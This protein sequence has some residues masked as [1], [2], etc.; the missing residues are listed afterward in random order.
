MERN[1]RLGQ[2][3]F[4]FKCVCCDVAFLRSGPDL[5]NSR[6]SEKKKHRK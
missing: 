6:S 3:R 1:F 5:H 4:A 2:K